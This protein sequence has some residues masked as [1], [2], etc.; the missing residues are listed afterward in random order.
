MVYKVLFLFLISAFVGVFASDDYYLNCD[1]EVFHTMA[2][3]WE[4]TYNHTDDLIAFTYEQYS[5]VELLKERKQW[6]TELLPERYQY[7]INPPDNN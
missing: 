3:T 7:K 5:D 1:P 2:S 6:I 4:R